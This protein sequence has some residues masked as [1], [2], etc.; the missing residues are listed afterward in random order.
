M[1][2]RLIEQLRL[3]GHSGGC[4][5]QSCNRA[6]FEVESG[7]SPILNVSYLSYSPAFLSNMYSGL[8][9]LPAEI[10][11]LLFRISFAAT[12][13]FFFWIFF[14]AMPSWI[15]FCI[16]CNYLLTWLTIRLS[17]WLPLFQ[18]AQAHLL[19]T[20]LEHHTSASLLCLIILLYSLQLVSV[21]KGE[22]LN[23]VSQV[24]SHEYQECVKHVLW[25]VRCSLG[26]HST[27]SVHHS[28]SKQLTLV[29]ISGWPL[30]RWFSSIWY[31]FMEFF[32]SHS[33]SYVSAFVKSHE[34]Y[35][36]PLSPGCWDPSKSSHTLHCIDCFPCFVELSVSLSV[37]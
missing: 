10:L 11:F 22:K 8:T 9:S 34:I 6:S 30:C 19:Q 21:L 28:K 35:S 16:F 18:A 3:E 36:Q 20:V 29:S 7:C 4:I 14:S 25:L 32:L 23:T 26:S 2:F 27:F 13:A 31:C 1:Y 12:R 17:M 33:R 37:L 15:G 5:I 24:W